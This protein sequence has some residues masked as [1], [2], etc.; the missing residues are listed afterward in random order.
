M[1]SV[2]PWPE[3]DPEERWMVEHLEESFANPTR[4]PEQ[5]LERAAELRAMAAD[6][7]VA[8]M[9]ETWLMLAARYEDA[10]SRAPAR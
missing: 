8:P 1:D 2:P 3:L 6:S 7:D 10:A 9:R 4:P 5:L